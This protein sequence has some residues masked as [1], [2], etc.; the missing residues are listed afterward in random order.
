MASALA[1]TV[2]GCGGGVESAPANQL[3]DIR[4]LTV[5]PDVMA[6]G[7]I[8]V[9]QVSAMDPDGDALAYSWSADQG[10]TVAADAEDPSKATVTAPAEPHVSGT[11]TVE[12]TD[13]QNGVA[14]ASIPVATST[15]I[16]PTI[17]SVSALPPSVEP[18]GTIAL[19]AS[20]NDPDEG[21][22]NYSWTAPEGWTLTADGSTAS[23]VAPDEYGVAATVT[24]E[25]DDGDDGKA[26]AE[27]VVSTVANQGPIIA[28]ITAN[29]QN[30]ARGGTIALAASATD[31]NGDPLGYVWTAPEGWTLSELADNTAV[32]IAPDQ[33]NETATVGLSVSSTGLATVGSIVVST[34]PNNAPQ[35]ASLLA[36]PNPTTP[37]GTLTVSASANDLDADP[38]NYLWSI[39]D[40]AWTILGS[41]ATATVT[42]PETL[43]DFATVT[44]QVSDDFS[45]T[46]SGQVVVSTGTSC[47]AGD[48]EQEGACV[49]CGPGA[50]LRDNPVVYWRLGE[51][52][53]DAIDASGNANDGTYGG[54]ETRAQLTV[55]DDGDASIGLDGATTAATCDSCVV[56]SAF[57]DFPTDALT[58][59]L[60]LRS[61]DDDAEGTSGRALVSYASTAAD[62]DFI[63]HNATSL[64]VFVAGVS[65]N[66]G[67]NLVDGRWHHLAVSWRSSDGDTRVYVDGAYVF[68]ATHQMG[69]SI[70]AGGTVVLGQEQDSIGGGFN[71]G[72]S[73][74][75]LLDEVAVFD[76]V[77]SDVQ[78]AQHFEAATCTEACDGV[79]NDADGSVD[80][81]FRGSDSS[82]AAL[83][84]SEIMAE[85]Q[86]AGDGLYWVEPDGDLPPQ[87]AGAPPI[88]AYCNMSVDGGGWT[89][90]QRTRWTWAGMTEDL[91]TGYVE[92]HDNTIGLPDVGNAYRL[93]GVRWP[94]LGQQGDLMIAH[95]VR[96]DSGGACDPLYYVGTGATVSVDLANSGATIAGL[97]QPVPLINNTDITTTDSGLATNCINNSAV[98]WFYGSCCT[99]CPTFK[100]GYWN[101]D[102]HPM[103]SYTG[104][105]ADFFG[106]VETDVCGGQAVKMS[107]NGTA[108]RGVDTMAVYL[109]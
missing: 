77:L 97:T 104:S 99:S 24:L 28:S 36:L 54:G 84:C 13:S 75:G 76:S 89:L 10:F 62:N 67:I 5:N 53:G 80:E 31:P 100:G 109:R 105:A 74:R 78:I 1:L 26:S 91:F 39:D 96:T 83:S 65:V 2:S 66:T 70:T 20:A 56:R 37:N 57:D 68:G 7:G 40:P 101:D 11:I 82:C 103:Q 9:A 79:D 45:G 69:A 27:L 49:A 21:E 95:H 46:V 12:I 51:A 108:Y 93:A 60:W 107:E 92:W 25:V 59:E 48:I 47:A 30:V 72:Q 85:G 15:N 32:L 98:P 42:A 16:A 14:T 19:S 35:L 33:P 55:T 29:P 34:L 71:A 86:S 88:N 87:L 8:A 22:L 58:V 63:V 94:D 4:A 44:V 43:S 41:G 64:S 23:L 38:L 81:G 52:A 6:R 61:D 50:I 17:A 106:N 18:G 3:P 90:I 102:P 73:F